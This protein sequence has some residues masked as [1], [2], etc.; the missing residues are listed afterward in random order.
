MTKR[1]AIFSTII[2]GVLALAAG[3]WLGR[4]R[5]PTAEP[6]SPV[7][8]GM[9]VVIEYS[10]RYTARGEPMVLDD[11]SP[12]RPVKAFADRAAADAHCRE[13]DRLKRSN[14][15][16]Y[17]PVAPDGG[18]GT[19]LDS[20]ATAGAASV[21]AAVRAEGLTPPAVASN[22]FYDESRAWAV[23]WNEHARGWEAGR[24]ARLWAALDR[25]RC[26]EVVPVPAAP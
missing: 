9:Y 24:R 15:F 1:Y 12:G 5:Q 19:F 26:Y 11:G 6:P 3:F 17:L 13:I 7:P 4:P 18:G 22:D 25:L 8:R 2:V 14:P 16:L 20:Y 10:W 23:W 21:L